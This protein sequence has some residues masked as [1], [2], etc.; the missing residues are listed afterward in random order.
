MIYANGLTDN[1][2]IDPLLYADDFK[3]IGPQ[4]QAAALQSFLVASSK[5]PEDWELIL[6]PPNVSTSIH[7]TCFLTPRTSP[8]TQPIQTVTSVHDLELL[9]DT[10]FSADDNVARATA[11]ARGVFFYLK[12]SLVTLT[13]SIFL[14]LYKAFIR[15]L[16]CINN[17]SILPHSL[18]GL[19]GVRKYSNTWGE[20]CK[21]AAPRPTWDSPPSPWKNPWWPY[22]HVQNNARPS[23]HSVRRSFCCP[24]PHL[25]SRSFFQDSPTAV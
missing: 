12:R 13:P 3:L 25:A 23:R 10:G 16:S 1:R 18:L 9:L 21:G 6:H 11:K 19:P 2:T 5:W 22:L 14:L 24:H 15:L 4:K 7:A 8:N 20:V 17:T